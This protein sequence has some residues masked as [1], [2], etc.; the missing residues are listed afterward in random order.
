MPQILGHLVIMDTVAG[1]A[2]SDLSA[3]D[4]GE[5]RDL[6]VALQDVL[7]ALEIDIGQLAEDTGRLAEIHR[8]AE[9]LGNVFFDAGL[10]LDG[11]LFPVQAAVF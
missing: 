1:A 4:M 2:R 9:Q 6:L 11:A 10:P 8:M 5:V 3:G 7:T